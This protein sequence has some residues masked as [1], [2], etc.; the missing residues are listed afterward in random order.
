MAIKTKEL[1][2]TCDFIKS[3]FYW[4]EGKYNVNLIVT[5]M[6][7]KKLHREYFEFQLN[8]IDI[9]LLERNIGETQEFVKDINIY[10]GIN[11]QQKIWNW[12]N[13][14]FR[15]KVNQK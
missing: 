1:L 4:K 12:I 10:K 8:K 5:E 13:P 2:D 15:R 11:R 9:M 3:N 7:L 14:T 6:S